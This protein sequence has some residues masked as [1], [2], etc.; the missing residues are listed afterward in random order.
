MAKKDKTQNLS[1]NSPESA[2][3]IAITRIVNAPRSL[4]YEV[5]TDPKHV[6]NWWG[7]TGFTNTIHEMDVR[8]G[9]IW[10]LTMHGPDGTDYPNKIVFKEVVKPERLVWSHGSDEDPDQFISTVTFVAQGKKTEIH[11]RMVFRSKEHRD[12]LVEK[13]GAIEGNTQTIDRLEAYL[14][15]M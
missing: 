9:G 15:K 11:M 2:R 7:P 8:P 5:W 10:R 14:A 6:V 12:M 4:V 1:D 3:E 13:F